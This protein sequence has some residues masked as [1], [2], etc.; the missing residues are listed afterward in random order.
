MSRILLH[1]ETDLTSAHCGVCISSNLS[2]HHLL[3]HASFFMHRILSGH[4][5]RNITREH[6]G[7]G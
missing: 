1:L 7:S 6:G 4:R 2:L 3:Y 5:I